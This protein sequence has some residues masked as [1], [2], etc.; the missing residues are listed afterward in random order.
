MSL[1]LEEDYKILYESGLQYVEDKDNRF[2]IIRNYPVAQG[3]YVSS[4]MPVTEVEVLVII[5]SNYNMSGT[6][7]LWTHPSISRTDNGPIPAV[8]VYGGNDNR[9]FNSKEYCRWSRH[10]EG[11]SWKAK[12][13]NVQKIL[14]RIEWALRNPSTIA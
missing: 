2:L 12:I 11:S 3:L 9:F 1:L 4:G 6:D 5:P 8:N 7:M 13:D 10:Y 14:S